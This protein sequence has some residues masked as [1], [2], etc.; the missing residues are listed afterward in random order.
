MEELEHVHSVEVDLEA[1][2]RLTTQTAR[3]LAD[4]KRLED[5]GPAM[6]V[7]GQSMSSKRPLTVRE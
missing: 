5:T 3:L 1:E 7:L 4:F 2:F 6:E